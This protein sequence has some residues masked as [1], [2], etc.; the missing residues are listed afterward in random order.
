MSSSIGGNHNITT[1]STSWGCGCDPTQWKILAQ[2]CGGAQM[3]AT[4][5][6]ACIWKHIVHSKKKSHWFCWLLF[7]R[8]VVLYSYLITM[9]PCTPERLEEAYRTL[10]PSHVARVLLS[11][12]PL[13][14]LCRGRR[15]A[16]SRSIFFSWY[17]FLWDARIKLELTKE[18]IKQ[19]LNW[20]NTRWPSKCFPL[21]IKGLHYTT[22]FHSVSSFCCPVSACFSMGVLW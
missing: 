17:K 4:V 22:P 9:K 21:M 12:Q 1:L 11:E 6:Y 15:D 18:E 19:E 7:H 13:Q 14:P 5:T 10:Q 16:Q 3:Q 20:T 8:H 2:C